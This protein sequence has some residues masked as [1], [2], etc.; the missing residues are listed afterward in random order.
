MIIW[1][2]YGILAPIA[3]ILSLALTEVL[4]NLSLK[5]E[6]YYQSHGWPKFVALAIAGLI[7][8]FLGRI[9]NKESKTYIEKST[10]KEVVL[11]KS[12]TFFF[13]DIKYWSYIFPILGIVYWITNN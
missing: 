7:C 6:L 12:H 1:S 5:D 2:R 8:F 13:I 11:K 4:V 3:A 10:G 9:L